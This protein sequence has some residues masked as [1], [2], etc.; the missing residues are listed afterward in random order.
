MIELESRL[1]Q[2]FQEQV[3]D[4]PVPRDPAGAAVRGA[5]RARRR[6]SVAVAAS[7]ALTVLAIV[8]GV[9]AVRIAHRSDQ[10]PPASGPSPAVVSPSPVPRLANGPRLDVMV[11]QTLYTTDGVAIPLES[12]GSAN[13]VYRVPDGWLV[14]AAP[15]STER[16]SVRQSLWLVTRD[17]ALT[18]L[19]PG[20]PKRSSIGHVAVSP[21]GRRLTYDE[22]SQL[23]EAALSGRKLDYLHTSPSQDEG[24]PLA[25]LRDGGVLLAASDTRGGQ[26]RYDVWWPDEG[27]FVPTWAD[28]PGRVLGITGDGLVLGAF[29][30]SRSACLTTLD[31]VNKLRPVGN[32]CSSA[33]TT[34]VGVVSPDGERVTIMGTAPNHELGLVTYDLRTLYH[35]G[36]PVA[37]WPIPTVMFDWEDDGSLLGV[38]NRQ[39]LIRMRLDKP[40][41]VENVPVP[42][43]SPLPGS[44][45]TVR[46]VPRYGG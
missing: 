19:A 37:W 6:R 20:D 41:N 42:G 9:G 29:S 28:R 38:T 7:A 31:P 45:R 15:I 11:D 30:G 22:D 13:E 8:G 33:F 5:A 26:D 16:E 25:Y 35:G 3:S 43:P 2:T 40:G 36:Q 39:G 10:A 14:L 27:P 23:I 12:L 34:D 1:R 44:S 24:W 17:G 46:L 32:N 4:A 21:D 18:R